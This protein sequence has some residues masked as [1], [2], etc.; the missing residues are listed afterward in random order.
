MR[1]AGKKALVTA[2]G[3]GIGKA[4]AERFAPDIVRR[5][6]S[7][8]WPRDLLINVNFPPIPPEHI[9][10]IRSCGQGRR[11]E[12]TSISEGVDPNGRPYLWIGNYLNDSTSERHTDLAAIME[13][14][15]AVTPLH[16]DLTHKASLK[17]LEEAF[18]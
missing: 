16:L 1:L 3:Q 4:T 10:G 2:A 5:L 13:G 9:T 18:A 6:V 8:S 7:M 14:A 11:T 12:G 17:R 15:I